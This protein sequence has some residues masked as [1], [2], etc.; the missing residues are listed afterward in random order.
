MEAGSA[1]PE[2]PYV[3]IEGLPQ[4]FRQTSDASPLAVPEGKTHAGQV[5]EIKG[6]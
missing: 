2:D 1:G 6:Y 4:A 3:R 5:K